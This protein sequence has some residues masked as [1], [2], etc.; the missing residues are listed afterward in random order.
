MKQTLIYALVIPVM[1]QFACSLE[2]SITSAYDPSALRFSGERARAIEADFVQ[3]FPNRS[4]GRENNRLAAEWLRN[5]FT[6]LGLICTMDKWQ[7]VNYSKDV[8]LQN[9]IC[10]LPGE[11]AQEIVLTAHFDQS[12]L[13]IQGADNDGSG[14]AILIH[15][16]EI[17]AAQK[18]L[19]HTLVFLAADGEEY[20][21]LGARRYVQ[22]HPDT[23]RIAA[24]ISLDNLGNNFYNGLDI[25]SRGQFRRYG[26]LWIQ[27]MAQEVAKAAGDL[28][29]PGIVPPVDQILSQ[30]VPI[31]FVDNGPFIAAGIP[32]LNFGGHVPPEASARYWDLY[33]SP[34][35]TIENQSAASLYQAGR[36]TEALMRQ[37]LS[38]ETFPNESGPYIYLAASQRVLRGVP[39]WSLFAA[40]VALFFVGAGVAG[41]KEFRRGLKSWRGPLLRFLSLWWPLLA[42]IALLYLFVAVGLMD[43][44]ALYP[45]TTKDPAQYTP[46]WAAVTL[47]LVG[48]AIFLWLGRRIAARTM[49]VTTVDSWARI[50]SLAL[51]V[52]GL[53][54]VY[55]AVI[56]P[57]S[58]LFMLPLLFWLL[59][60]GRRGAW[61]TFDIIFFLLGGLVVYVLFYFFG[62]VVLHIDLAVLWYLMMMFSVRMV[63]FPTALAITAI[64]GAGLMM[65]INPPRVRN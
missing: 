35:D 48:L 43:K 63:S 33:H 27:R 51:L 55:L 62:Y 19:A 20:G 65:V 4:S 40:L 53:G 3:R 49:K 5:E 14:I 10:T 6:R 30:A 11:S 52:L 54:A 1:L 58:L 56:N 25:D 37:L 46:K 29:I 23:S 7:V 18:P 24:G 47:W 50:K 34:N 21:M 9:V 45:A 17:F 36:V 15:L 8:P 13:T 12:P 39:L 32:A 42:A 60:S 57:F 26:P 22:T 59:I 64:I 2:P 38:M 41:R 31:S 28:W 16:A 44:Y 61:K